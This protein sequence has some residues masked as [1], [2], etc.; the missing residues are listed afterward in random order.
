LRLDIEPML[1]WRSP[2][3]TSSSPM[4]ETGGVGGAAIRNDSSFGGVAMMLAAK[5]PRMLI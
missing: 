1:E 2:R 4:D 3:D 5:N